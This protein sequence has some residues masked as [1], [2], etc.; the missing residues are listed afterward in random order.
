[1]IN[2]DYPALLKLFPEYLDPKRSE[3]AS[4]LIWYL[5]NYYRVD[6]LDAVDSVCDQKGDKGVDGIFVNDSDQTITIFQSKISQNAKSTIGDV[7][8]KEFA[9]TISQFETDEKIDHLIK[10]AGAAQVGSLAKRLE[11]SKKIVT[12]ELRG[13]FI[14]NIDLDANGI[15]FL[16]MAPHISV[17]GKADLLSTY[18]SDERDLPVHAPTQFDISGFGV[19]EYIVDVNTKAVIAPIK[20]KELVALSGIADQSLFVYNVRGPLGRTQVNRDIVKTIKSKESHKLFP[21]FHSGITVIAGGLDVAKD[22]LTAS[23]YFVVNGCQSLTALFNN[24]GELTD[25]LRILAKFIKMDPRS[26][27]AVLNPTIK[28]RFDCKMNS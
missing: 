3:S 16:K 14:S 8:L 11:L 2:V 23:D 20:A 18:I 21:L 13:E 15:S 10:T 22:K 1:M 28:S 24:K 5:E 26:D 27:W 6:P 25:D 19:S 17:V 7:A 9:G 4:F 12:Y